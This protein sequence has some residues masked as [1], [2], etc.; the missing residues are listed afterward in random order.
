MYYRWRFV[1]LR[2]MAESEKYWKI[3]QIVERTEVSKE[4]IHHY[5]RQGILPQPS[6]RA[7]YDER[8][9]RLLLLIKK[10]RDEHTLPLEVI[11]GFFELFE[12]EPD[13]IEPLLLTESLSQRLTRLAEARDLGLSST[14]SLDEVADR[15]DVSVEELT[16]YL[17]LKLIKPLSNGEQPQFTAY[18]ANVVSLFRSGRSLGMSAESFRTIASYVRIAFELEHSEFFDLG[19]LTVSPREEGLRALFLRREIVSGFVQNVYQSLVQGY[20]RESFERPAVRKTGIDAIVYRPSPQFV[21]RHGLEERIERLSE[22]VGRDPERSSQW[23]TTAQLYLH[24]GRYREAVFFLEQGLE[25]WPRNGEL[26]MLYGIALILSGENE[27][28]RRELERRLEEGEDSS[29]CQVYLAL[30]LFEQAMS[31]TEKDKTVTWA[32][33]GALTARALS[34]VGQGP[35]RAAIESF[36]GWILTALPRAFGDWERG[37]ELL[38]KTLEA[39]ERGTRS[40]RRATGLEERDMINAAYLLFDALIRGDVDEARLEPLRSIICRLDPASVFARDVYLEQGESR[41]VSV[42]SRLRQATGSEGDDRG[43]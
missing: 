16:E 28:G 17:E 10:L 20:L 5:L 41:K 21:E 18:D 43:S 25:R 19:D 38:E 4:L 36:A 32:R 12:F 13:K 24:A 23:L 34:S 40:T 29:L 22:K 42:L 35:N 3:A 14:L 26:R 1:G 39:L 30:A 15:V 2:T 11:R 37:C 7:R 8:H 6:S 31:A 33:V 27:R 9:V